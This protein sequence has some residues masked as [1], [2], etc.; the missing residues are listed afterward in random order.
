VTDAGLAHLEGCKSLQSLDLSSTQVTDEGLK[1]IKDLP[2]LQT[3]ILVSC[4]SVT[5]AGL[6]GVKR[7][8]SL[9]LSRSKD[10]NSPGGVTDAN[11]EGL[12]DLHSLETLD[13]T[14]NRVGDE[15]L[16]HLRG[17]RSL[18]RLFLSQTAVTDAGMECLL[19]LQN[20]QALEVTRTQVTENG[21]K[22]IKRAFPKC[23][24]HNL[25]YPSRDGDDLLR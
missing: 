24:L 8:L 19:N 6:K 5:S 18:Q 3:L 17:L 16:N 1:S 13:L 15:G 7:L 4:D 14:G 21:L 9:N 10:W 12:K 22:R 20:L 25:S 2:C 11:L 23:M